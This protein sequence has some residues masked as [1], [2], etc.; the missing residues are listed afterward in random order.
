MRHVLLP[1]P[2]G[3]GWGEGS[4]YGVG[5]IASACD[6]GPRAWGSAL[7]PNEAPLLVTALAAGGSVHLQNRSVTGT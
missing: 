7:A 1:L 3:E 6:Q 5:E 2:A 4:E